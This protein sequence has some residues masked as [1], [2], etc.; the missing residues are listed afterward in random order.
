MYPDEP[1]AR[2]VLE[3]VQMSADTRTLL[4]TRSLAQEKLTGLQL[5][6]FGAF[7]KRSWR[8]NDCFFPTHPNPCRRGCPGGSRRARLGRLHPAGAGPSLPVARRHGCAL[9][10]QPRLADCGRSRR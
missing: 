4:D 9:S 2:Q 5:H 7:Y 6:H 8:A 10:E 3:L 1:A